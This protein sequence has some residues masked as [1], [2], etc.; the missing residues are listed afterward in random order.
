MT[1]ELTIR[2]ISGPEELGLFNSLP[3]VLNEELADDLAIGR[4]RAAWMW[5]AT[6][7]DGVVA[8]IAWWGRESE[9]VP[10]L[11]DLFDLDEAV[12]DRRAVGERLVAAAMAAVVPAGREPPE[13]LRMVPSDWAD[14]PAPVEERMAILAG[15]GARPLVERLRFEWRP[16][17]P[18]PEP[19]GRLAFRPVRDADEMVGLM[20]DVLEGTLDAHSRD[21]LRSMPPR[22]AAREHFDRE[23]AHYRSPREWWLVGTL[24]DGEPVG[25]ACPAR[26]DYGPIIGYIAVRPAHRGNGYIDD[27]LGEATRFLAGQG[28]PRIRAA[29]DVANV[30]MARAFE[31]AGYLNFERVV[32]MVWSAPPES[33]AE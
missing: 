28:V 2:P 16:G 26:N 13:Y 19:R 21:D 14:R 3:Y 5:V 6:R 27:L 24:P 30:P 7:G 20:I 23:L 10:L 17:T 33:G 15:T 12:P 9:P 32:T 22:E 31:R 11:L 18:L 8:R 4:R 25:F 29:T 1:D